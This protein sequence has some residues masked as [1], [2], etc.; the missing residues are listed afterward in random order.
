[1]S[2]RVDLATVQSLFSLKLRKKGRKEGVEKRS[3]FRSCVWEST[4]AGVRIGGIRHEWEEFEGVRGG[5][6]K[7]LRPKGTEGGLFKVLQRQGNETV[8]DSVIFF[9]VQDDCLSFGISSILGFETWRFGGVS[10]S[11]VD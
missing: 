6:S 9:Y 11:Q 2:E 1:M 5:L 3:R 10:S 8:V 7:R 4:R